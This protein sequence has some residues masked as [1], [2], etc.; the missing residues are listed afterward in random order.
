MKLKIKPMI[1][2]FK[3]VP[4]YF[5]KEAEGVKPCTVRKDDPNDARFIALRDCVNPPKYIEIVNAGNTR[6][7]F[8]REITDISYW[9][10]DRLW[11]ISWKHEES[12]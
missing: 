8:T 11:I 1:I 5:F 2:Q 6:M 10:Q 4:L 9:E 3:S 7:G 12:K